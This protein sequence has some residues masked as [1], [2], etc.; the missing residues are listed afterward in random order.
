MTKY[1]FGLAALLAL[2]LGSQAAAAVS[3]SPA[4]IAGSVASHVVST[5]SGQCSKAEAIRAVK[6]LGLRDVSATYPVWKVLC[7]HFTAAGNETMVVS[8]NG[9]GN[10]G[11]LY[12]AVFQRTGSEWQ[13][14]TKQRHA[15]ILTA[16]GSDIRETQSIYRDSDSRCCPSGG[17]KARIWHWDGARF[18]ASPWQQ[19]TAESAGQRPTRFDS[20]SRN[21]HCWMF[22]GSGTYNRGVGC[23]SDTPPRFAR[24]TVDGRLRVTRPNWSKCGCAEPDNPPLAYGK[25]ITAGRFRCQSLQ[26]GVRCTVIRSGKGFLINRDGVS[27]VGA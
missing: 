4:Y 3:L 25:Q 8:V 1:A 14:L 15:A 27:R 7:G 26:N 9:D 10:M 19:A 11:M 24:L 18:V 12:W 17:T 5:E 20:P 6:R 16:A 21:I 23:S 22:D 13:F 2:T